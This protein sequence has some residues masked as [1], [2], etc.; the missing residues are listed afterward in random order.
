MLI[1][2]TL[3]HIGC[4]SRCAQGISQVVSDRCV[5]IVTDCTISTTPVSDDICICDCI[6][7]DSL[8]SGRKHMV[9]ILCW[10][11]C[12]LFGVLFGV[13]MVSICALGLALHSM[14]FGVLFGVHMVSIC[15]LGSALHSMVSSVI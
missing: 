4:C 2:H 1:S 13:H 3:V 11:T 5:D 12:G 14:L 10:C 9:V 6:I 8:K 7:F 15:A